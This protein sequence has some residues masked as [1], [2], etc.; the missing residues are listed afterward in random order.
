MSRRVEPGPASV[1]FAWTGG[2]L[3]AAS[4][5][6]FLFAY[7]VRFG[8]ATAAQS[9]ATT[10]AAIAWNVATFTA[11]AL[12]H[13][14]L[15]R[16][17]VKPRIAAVVGPPLERS[18]YVWVA[19]LLFLAV[20]ASW[21][22][23]PG[24]FWSVAWPA[25]LPLSVRQA[26]GVV[27][28]LRAAA[29]IDVLDLAGVRSMRP[30]RTGPSTGPSTGLATDRGYGR[31]RHP[32]YLAWLLLVWPASVMTGT[33]LTF[34]AVSTLYLIVAIPF[35]ERDVRKKFGA[36]YEAYCRLVKWR[37]VPGIW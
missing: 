24:L 3:F 12:H 37:I 35:E 7:L 25:R 34:A 26:V 27:L 17:G 18:T 22:P 32:I 20:C 11:F 33:R 28:T 10:S 13:S 30:V 15:A 6:Y 14:V 21:R 29:R 9:R 31:V 19:S 4:L 23:V 36:E 5:L 1:A 16:S 8:D 2:A